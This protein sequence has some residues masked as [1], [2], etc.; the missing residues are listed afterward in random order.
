MNSWSTDED[1]SELSGLEYYVFHQCVVAEIY[2]EL[3]LPSTQFFSRITKTANGAAQLKVGCTAVPV[4]NRWCKFWTCYCEETAGGVFPSMLSTETVHLLSRYVISL[5]QL[6]SGNK[7]SIYDVYR[8]KSI[9]CPLWYYQLSYCL[10]NDLLYLTFVP[11]LFCLYY[12][13]H[14]E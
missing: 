12:V 13:K 14:F 7:L 8:F 9:Y 6:L 11:F 3:Q 1:K 4:N 10:W 5:A 2:F